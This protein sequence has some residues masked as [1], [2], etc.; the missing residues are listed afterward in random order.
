M[1]E[2]YS[3]VETEILD[4]YGINGDVESRVSFWVNQKIRDNQS[5]ARGRLNSLKR[6]FS[7]LTQLSKN[8]QSEFIYQIEFYI[9]ENRL[10]PYDITEENII[11]LSKSFKNYGKLKLW[12]EL[13]TMKVFLIF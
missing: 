3:N 11:T 2:I 4:V 5:E 6:D 10:K 9:N 8:Q 13:C 7:N 12:G 1:D